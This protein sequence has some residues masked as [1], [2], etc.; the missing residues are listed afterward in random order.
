VVVESSLPLATKPPQ[1]SQLETAPLS[2]CPDHAKQSDH[3][4]SYCRRHHHICDVERRIVKVRAS[5]IEELIP[6]DHPA[7]F[8]HGEKPRSEMRQKPLL[9]HFSASFF[10]LEPEQTGGR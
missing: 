3:K 6:N 2:P 9:H 4:E 5:L 8:A 7:D 10:C 1:P